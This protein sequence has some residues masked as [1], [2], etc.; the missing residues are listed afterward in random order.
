MFTNFCSVPDRF[1]NG[2][3]YI[4]R[5]N[6]LEKLTDMMGLLER[7]FPGVRLTAD[8]SDIARAA[9]DK[10]A[11]TVQLD[12]L[13]SLPP[14]LSNLHCKKRPNEKFLNVT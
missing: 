9:A 13:R 7:W 3:S 12:E 2:K 11:R 10:K 4:Y 14:A 1:L 6:A 8:K 5:A